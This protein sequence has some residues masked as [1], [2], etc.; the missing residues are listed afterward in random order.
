MILTRCAPS[1]ISFVFRCQ[2]FIVIYILLL[3]DGRSWKALRL[4]QT[5]HT[6]LR[7]SNGADK[8][9]IESFSST[10]SLYL[11]LFCLSSITS[12]LTSVLNLS[13]SFLKDQ[14]FY[15]EGIL[16]K[17]EEIFVWLSTKAV[18]NNAK[19]MNCAIHCNSSCAVKHYLAKS[20]LMY[21]NAHL[22]FL[23]TQKTTTSCIS[24][25]KTR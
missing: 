9:L 4:V 10:P 21:G 25:G 24:T 22:L 11:I 8:I 1:S 14:S 2:H 19:G 16:I 3:A 23:P 5:H 7:A 20:S 18:K 12:H 13:N 17:F 15:Q 6:Y